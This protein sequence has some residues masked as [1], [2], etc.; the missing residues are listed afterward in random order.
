MNAKDLKKSMRRSDG[1]RHWEERREL[2]NWEILGFK[3]TL[4][5]IL[6]GTIMQVFG[7][8]IT[9]SLGV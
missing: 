5:I 9:R 7:A 8:I 3:L 1:S 6:A 4:A 2:S